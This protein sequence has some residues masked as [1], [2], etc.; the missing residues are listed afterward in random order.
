M[1]LRLLLVLCSLFTASAH[2]ELAETLD[3]RQ[4]PSLA[5]EAW[6]LRQGY[7]TAE[8]S[9][10]ALSLSESLL[11]AGAFEP[12]AA[13]FETWTRVHG[14]GPLQGRALLGLARA[15]VRS[16][17]FQ[18][19]V[20]A[21][22]QAQA[23]GG[24]TGVEAALVEADALFEA[25]R[26]Q[27]AESAYA[28][29]AQA[30]AGLS[31][32]QAAYLPYA[33]GWCL[34]RQA[35]LPVRGDAASNTRA[36]WQQAAGLF[37]DAAGLK[38]SRYAPTA[39]YQQA[40]CLYAL[41]DWDA[42]ADAYQQMEKRYDGHELVPAARYSLG[43]CRFEQKKFRDAAT[44]FHRFSIV[45]ADH[46]LAPWGLYMAGVS[47]ARA[48]DLDLAESAYS[49]GLR[50]YPGNEAADRMQYGLAWLATSRKDYEAAATEWERFLKDYPDSGLAP[51]ASF[52]L[53]DSQ[54]QEKRYAG[55][56]DQ[57]LSLLKRYPKDPL[58]ED[59]L[60]YAASAS[61]A[62]GELAQARDEFQQF[63]RLRPTSDKA[64]EAK[65]RLA[66]C[67][68]G[69]G[70]LDSAETLYSELRT[71][72]KGGPL[73]G[74]AGMGLGWVAFSRRDWGL[75]G[76]RFKQAAADLDGASRTEA[77]LRA[78]DAAFNGGDHNAALTAYR[79]AAQG[80][81]PAGL[82]AEAHMGA[83]WAAYRLKDFSQA[84]GEWGNAQAQADDD[85]LRAEAAYWM[86]WAL[87]RQGRWPEAAQA[88]ASLVQRWPDSHLVPNALVQ[89]GNS[90]QN[91]GR[92][93]E[94]VPLYRQVAEGWP[95]HAQAGAAL[96]GLQICYSALGKDDEAVAVAKDFVKKNANSE[97]APQVQYQVAE[98]YLA[99]KDFAKAEKE[100]DDLKTAY[101]KS[102]V[103]ITATYWRGQ[104]RFK[105][106]KFNEAIQ[107]WKDV[108]ARA[109]Q[110]PL[111]PR[112]L[113]KSGLAWY[114][115]QEY[116]QA[117]A[118]FKQV[119]E[120][121]GNTVDVA[122]DA[123]FNLGLTYKR[124]GRDADAVKAYQEVQ[125]KHPGTE[126]ASMA[127][128]RIGYI[129]EDAGDL[130]KAATAYRALAA[131]DKGKLG[132]EAQYLVGDCLLAQKKSGEALLAYD[133]VQ[134]GF[135]G[136]SGWVVTALAKSGEILE[137][138]GRDKDALERYQKIVN[139]GGDPSWVSSAQKRMEL[140]R[141]R[142]S[143][144]VSPTPAKASAPKPKA[145]KPVKA[146]GKP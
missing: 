55:A 6:R 138:L 124:M 118:T 141:Q 85:S 89:Q 25:G 22:R 41:G 132:A 100:L 68:Y 65:R 53:A 70:K 44:A 75:A 99:K 134:E 97:V 52:L 29:L 144:A 2:A 101:P 78:G 146:E 23:Q 4:A 19:A 77:W 84:Y 102:S 112:A 95:Q 69:L 74:E 96:H 129:Y 63:L 5:A 13:Q 105:N 142:M 10:A 139:L 116:S 120:A 24:S 140:I 3:A 56:H 79:Q 61:L 8:D 57:Y 50:K 51:S 131:V 17:E 119:L 66:D 106:L 9:S 108:A 114:R 1:T 38:G 28:R 117:E 126:L 72:L 36:V 145:K 30:P 104:A 16:G 93:E 15:R 94:A 81:G 59:A 80:A 14:A 115:L 121:Y 54:Y 133:A 31:A 43:W 86:G 58:A 18:A 92:C 125:E 98:H 67:L 76:T 71:A 90:L 37:A 130:E 62:Q 73:A 87:F 64:L 143:P 82:K 137:S 110:H 26:F 11:K 34:K 122:A 21:V 45:H 42:A 20:E 111:A 35:Q 7:G 107:D 103:D 88:Y 136:E 48:G 12:A 46:A 49:L 60:F 135:P 127:A 128:I 91:A 39:L 40:E 27:E 113:F 33:R 32:M 47:L 109:P 123:R 83:G